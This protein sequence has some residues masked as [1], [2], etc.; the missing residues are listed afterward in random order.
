MHP[1]VVTDAADISEPLEVLIFS[2][3]VIPFNVPPF[4]NIF[5]RCVALGN[6]IFY[7]LTRLHL[8][9]SKHYDA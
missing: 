6:N 8:A 7:H 3:A 5:A 9:M 1:T 2:P 4:P